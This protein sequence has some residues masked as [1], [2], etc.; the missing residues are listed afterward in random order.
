MTGATGRLQGKSALITGGASGIGFA[1]ARRFIDEG[2]RVAITDID[3]AKGT[4][5][6]AELGAGAVFHQH[7]VTSEAAWKAVA[8][9]V[10]GT[11][12]GMDVLV[13]CAGIFKLGPLEETSLADWRETIAI[14]LDGTFLGCQAAVLAMKTRGGGS[15][16]NLS[17]T[18]GLVGHG[19]TPAYNASKGG[20]RLLTKSVAL[21][22]AEKGYGIRC[23][24]VHP[25]G[26]DTPMVR[27]YFRLHPDPQGEAASWVGGT[28]LG[29]LGEASEIAALILYL[30]SDESRFVTGAELVIDGGTT[31][32]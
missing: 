17:S 31:A 7:D 3:E 5:A 24:S 30:A 4:A 14:N 32:Q 9:W 8:A 13:N 21:H 29:R 6:A 27:E 19:D 2:A 10:E 16:I 20:V 22:C 12:G 28:P 18:A 23:N 25:A 15:I 26:I 11:H 1:T